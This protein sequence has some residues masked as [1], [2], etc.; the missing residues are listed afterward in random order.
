MQLILKHITFNLKRY[1]E[2]K[3]RGAIEKFSTKWQ[4]NVSLFILTAQNKEL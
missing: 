1:S 4:V 3:L 2:G